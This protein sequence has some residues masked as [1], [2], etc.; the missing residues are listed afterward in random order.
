MLGRLSAN[1][2][3]AVWL[4]EEAASSRPML[5]AQINQAKAQWISPLVGVTHP[6]LAP[7]IRIVAPVVRAELPLAEDETAP[8]AVAIAELIAGR[9]LTQAIAHGPLPVHQSVRC[10]AYVAAAVDALHRRGAAH[11]SISDR[12]MVIERADEG[13]SPVLTQLSEPPFAA[14]ASPERLRGE[15]PSQQ[16]D[17]W[18]L[19][20]MLYLALVGSL[21]FQG[22]DAG[23]LLQAMTHGPVPSLANAGVDDEHLQ[24]VLN[25]GLHTSPQHRAT[26][27]FDFVAE[28]FD[29]LSKQAPPR[30]PSSSRLGAAQALNLVP[31]GPQRMSPSQNDEASAR[32]PYPQPR[33]A[34]LLYGAQ[35]V[36][37]SLEPAKVEASVPD[38]EFPLAPDVGSS[39][40]HHPVAAADDLENSLDT[41]PPSPSV[42]SPHCESPKEP[43]GFSSIPE[44]EAALVRPSRPSSARSASSAPAED[45]SSR[46]VERG[47]E[48]RAIPRAKSS[49]S[50]VEP[51]P[52]PSPLPGTH[53]EPISSNIDEN[54]IVTTT[55]TNDDPELKS[56]EPV[57]VV[58]PSDETSA[59]K[60]PRRHLAFGMGAAGVLGLLGLTVVAFLYA[61]KV[62]S[63]HFPNSQEPRPSPAPSAM[64]S[65]ADPWVVPTGS[66][67]SASIEEVEPSEPV[68][69]QP[70][71]ITRCITDFFPEGSFDGLQDLGF[72]CDQPDPRKGA[73]TMRS[74]V[75]IGA[76]GFVTPAMHE[77]S[78]LEWHE[79]AVWAIFR[80]VCCAEPS[81]L[82][83]PPPVRDCPSLAEAADGLG[84]AYGAG[85][86]LA[87]SIVQFQRAA[88]CAHVGK[89]SG[90][91]YAAGPISGGQ[92]TFAGFL[93]R[94]HKRHG[95]R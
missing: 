33:T 48:P 8:E 54:H 12:S 67:S 19:H 3:R 6:H 89:A 38:L 82:Q 29:W 86:S 2:R 31:S 65:N 25:R 16:D 7:I 40:E 72:V 43:Q 64:V 70:G 63:K 15:G 1:P 23:S 93:E 60:K 41:I 58:S 61:P 42:S 87:E 34:T 47:Q 9:T 4:A 51:K 75:V 44:L 92:V 32:R 73:L 18:A 88:E 26:S 85:E 90:Y 35:A 68:A 66:V 13:R 37:P 79:I 83:L 94:N 81:P 69:R 17:V 57:P 62:L 20:V 95:V 36:Q 52:A 55:E 84:R 30:S 21:P 14:F 50:E 78:R 22:A 24:R 5:V 11:G 10:T 49:E 46:A 80:H 27:V 77:W 39:V 53:A 56:R 71:D 28:L 74:R 45:T 76:R 91:R 59:R